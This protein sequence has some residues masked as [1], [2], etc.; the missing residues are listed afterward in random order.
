[1]IHPQNI[2][3][4]PSYFYLF[5]YFFIIY[6]LKNHNNMLRVY[7][8]LYIEK[9]WKPD[10]SPLLRQVPTTSTYSTSIHENTIP[11]IQEEEDEQVVVLTK[12]EEEEEEVESRQ[13]IQEPEQEVQVENEQK[14]THQTQKS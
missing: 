3:N 7:S 10:P 8:I 12:Q 13:I 11:S 1:M 14:G 9:L 6:L 4:V 2:K 5:F